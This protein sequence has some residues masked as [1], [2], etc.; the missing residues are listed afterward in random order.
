MSSPATETMDDQV[1]SS[2]RKSCEAC[3]TAKRRCDLTF[4]FCSRCVSKSLSCV[5]PGRQPSAYPDFAEED[6]VNAIW[7]Q[8]SMAVSFFSSTEVYPVRN[9]VTARQSSLANIDDG[10]W[11]YPH[12]MPE[13]QWL[14]A[15][16]KAASPFSYD[17]LAPRA[18]LPKPLS[19]VIASRFQFA[20][21]VLK[22]T[23]RMTVIEN[24]TAWC[25]PHLY[26]NH[27]PKAMKGEYN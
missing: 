14:A 16:E 5:Y 9:P 13:N 8:N 22:D 24:Q 1:A 4:P 7:Q 3:K 26:K 23:P 11:Q 12:H 17:L 2:R 15:L 20:I 18:R 25:H 6:P 10:Q 19:E 21:D 27:M